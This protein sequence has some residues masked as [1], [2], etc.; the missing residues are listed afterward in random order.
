MY[1][2]RKERLPWHTTNGC[3]DSGITPLHIACGFDHVPPDLASASDAIQTDPESINTKTCAVCRECST[4]LHAAAHHG[5]LEIVELLIRYGANT[6]AEDGCGSRALDIAVDR[7]DESMIIC[8]LD[9]MESSGSGKEVIAAHSDDQVGRTVFHHAAY[10]GHADVLKFLLVR[11]GNV[12]I[13][14]KDYWGCTLLLAACK[15]DD[16]ESGRGPIW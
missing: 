12:Q 4:P 15:G 6:N 1:E 5:S 7:G 16:I 11:L 14:T 13:E 3:P 2:E 8:L 9:A 10:A